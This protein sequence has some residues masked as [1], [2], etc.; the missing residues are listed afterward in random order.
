MRISEKEHKK[1]LKLY[2]KGFTD[3]EIA[4]KLGLTETPI[5]HWRNK[6]NLEPNAKI[7]KIDDE[8][9]E[10]IEDY[11]FE[12]FSDNKIAEKLGISFGTVILYRRRNN[13]P[14]NNKTTGK[15]KK[16]KH[17]KRLELYKKGLSD[18]EI[19]E[20]VGLSKAGIA[21]WR[22]RNK[23]PANKKYKLSEKEK[24]KR[25]KLYNEGLTDKELSKKL[26]LTV[27]GVI[28]WR[29]KNNLEPNK[30]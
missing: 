15:L 5:S 28:N 21:S 18:R 12:G 29:N 1:R 9:R 7:E 25:F 19:A 26:D 27:K 13:L 22:Y 10:Q 14:P 23:L 6:N 24:K 4:E 2:N 30:K 8:I 3:K 11:Y 16:K 20:K 17:N